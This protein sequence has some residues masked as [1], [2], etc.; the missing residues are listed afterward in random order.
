MCRVRQ[1][2]P[3]KIEIPH[4]TSAVQN[5]SRQ[6]GAIRREKQCHIGRITQ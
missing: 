3:D 4:N 2:K 5:T 1:L 6:P